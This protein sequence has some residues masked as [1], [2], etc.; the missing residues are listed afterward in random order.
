MQNY[1]EEPISNR[2]GTTSIEKLISICIIRDKKGFC[3]EYPSKIFKYKGSNI[4]L[5]IKDV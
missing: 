1:E 3:K 5:V 4:C 2:V